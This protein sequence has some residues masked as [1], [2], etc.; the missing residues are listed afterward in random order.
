MSGRGLVDVSVADLLSLRSSV[1]S[2]SFRAPLTAASLGARGLGH[3]SGPMAPFF[4]L[5]AAALGA[6]LEVALAEREHHRA[7]EISLVWTGDDPAASLAR[8][9]RILLPELFASARE[10]VLVAGYSFDRPEEMFRPLH[11]AMRDHGV[12]TTLFVDVGQLEP[13][14][15]EAARRQKLSW[16]DLARP[17]R[18]TTSPAERG[19]AIVAL[20]KRLMWPFGEPFPRVYFDPRTAAARPTASMHAKCVVIDRKTSLVTSANFTARGQTRNIEA[21]VVIQDPAF[22]RA[23]ALQ[24]S[25]LIE[26]GVVVS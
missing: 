8:H 9:T 25:N 19:Q 21:G 15:R 20:F 13:R 22:A 10:D 3:L 26:A 11:A 1:A 5:D 14:L 4:G 7:P 16:K 23:L 6:I 18:H 2:A 17:L 24:W 12:T